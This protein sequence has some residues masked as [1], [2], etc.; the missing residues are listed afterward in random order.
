M[1][2]QNIGTTCRE[3]IFSA[4][5]ETL[6][7]NQRV[8]FLLEHA[9]QSAIA[10][11]TQGL[12]A[13]PS[14][15]ADDPLRWPWQRFRDLFGALKFRQGVFVLLVLVQFHRGLKRLSYS[16]SFWRTPAGIPALTVIRSWAVTRGAFIGGGADVCALTVGHN[17]S[18]APKTK[19]R[20]KKT[21]SVHPSLQA[22]VTARG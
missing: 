12:A 20:F 7:K 21:V 14:R 13:L 2:N 10:H 19:P 22:I 8:G 6:E 9:L 17:T 4:S 3:K 15:P 1:A 11:V 5:R 18:R 16:A